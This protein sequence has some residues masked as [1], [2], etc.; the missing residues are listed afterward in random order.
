[1]RAKYYNSKETTEAKT[2][3]KNA[4]SIIPKI[5]THPIEIP[6]IP[7]HHHVRPTETKDPA[8]PTDPLSRPPNTF[9]TDYYLYPGQ[10]L[11]VIIIYLPWHIFPTQIRI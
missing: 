1:M 8:P 11:L 4:P 5:P 10:I 9:N 7:Q 2:Q 3:L 6:K